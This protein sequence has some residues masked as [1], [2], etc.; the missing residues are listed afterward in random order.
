MTIN[1]AY[2]SLAV[3]DAAQPHSPLMPDNSQNTLIEAEL[4]RTCCSPL[5]RVL[6]VCVSL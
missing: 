4:Y 2:R 1:A 6:F 3:A 5:S